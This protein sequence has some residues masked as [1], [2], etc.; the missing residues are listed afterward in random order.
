MSFDIGRVVYF[1]LGGQSEIDYLDCGE[2]IGVLK[3]YVFYLIM[4]ILACFEVPVDDI[5]PM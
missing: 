1:Q 4:G 5:Q 2:I 3:Q